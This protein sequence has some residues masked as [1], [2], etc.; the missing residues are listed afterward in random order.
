MNRFFTLTI[1]LRVWQW[2]LIGS[3]VAYAVHTCN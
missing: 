3:A 2:L 1:D